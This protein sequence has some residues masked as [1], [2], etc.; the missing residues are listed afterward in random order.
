MKKEDEEEDEIWFKYS[1][2]KEYFKKY[3]V[4]SYKS[5]FF[6]FDDFNKLKKKY[7]NNKVGFLPFGLCFFKFIHRDF[8][9]RKFYLN[10]ITIILSFLDI[11]NFYCKFIFFTTLCIVGVAI[12]RLEG[13]GFQISRIEKKNWEWDAD[14]SLLPVERWYL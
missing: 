7:L 8:I 9:K 5:R 13:E 6:I 11:K 14:I 4:K 2:W 10:I 12:R 3:P 1:D